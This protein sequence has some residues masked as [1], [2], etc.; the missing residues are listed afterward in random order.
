MSKASTVITMPT[1]TTT[2]RKFKAAMQPSCPTRR[3]TKARSGGYYDQHHGYGDGHDDAYYDGGH[4][5]G[6]HDE[7][8][9]D[10]YYDQGAPAAGQQPHYNQ[11]HVYASKLSLQASAMHPG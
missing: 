1:G 10:Q 6:Y 5:Q 3:L 8:Y 4:N 7:Y 9:D 2:R 11:Q